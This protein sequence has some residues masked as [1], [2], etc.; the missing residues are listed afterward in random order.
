MIVSA[1]PKN[2]P[3]LPA[4][5]MEETPRSSYIL[6]TR[7]INGV[8][9]SSSRQITFCISSSRIIKFV[10]EVSSS[11]KSSLEPL[12]TASIRFAACEVLPLAS[13]VEK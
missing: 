3:E 12:S 8:I 4:T 9:G 11:I 6:R 7:S 1:I 10:A 13:S 2:E 5:I